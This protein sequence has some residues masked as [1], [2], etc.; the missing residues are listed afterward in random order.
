MAC[1]LY[2]CLKLMNL[3]LMHI[4]VRLYM[5]RKKSAV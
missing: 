5:E 2:D 1:A 4:L 3:F